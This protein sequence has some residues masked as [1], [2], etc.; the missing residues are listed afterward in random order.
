MIKDVHLADVMEEGVIL[1]C[2]WQQGKIVK[3]MQYKL[4]L[5]P[6]LC[7]VCTP[8]EGEPVVRALEIDGNVD[9]HS[10]Y[11]RLVKEL[12]QLE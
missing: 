4:T 12:L 6:P 9:E 3:L 1:P 7:P 10:D 5:Y 8:E 2:C 11:S